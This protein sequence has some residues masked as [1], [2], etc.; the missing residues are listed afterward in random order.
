MS[1]A[2]PLPPHPSLEHYR[3]QAK[4]LLK[5]CRSG[6]AV[7]I[8]HWQI[9][10][11]LR[12]R[13]E[14]RLRDANIE[15][16]T[17]AQLFI[18]RAHGF[19]SWP[20]F[21]GHVE[22][23]G[24]RNSPDALFEAAVD[25]VVGGD[26]AAL[27]RLLSDHPELVHARSTREHHST[28]LHYA[29]AN[30]VEDFRQR[31]PP[32]IVD[33][34]TLLLDEGAGVNAESDA[35]GGRSTTLMLV[36]T[37]VHPERAGVQIAL[38][39]LLLGRGAFI[40]HRPATAVNACLA[41]GRVEAAEFLAARGAR[42]DLPGAAG[43]GR[44]DVVESFFRDAVPPADDMQRAFRYACQFDRAA[45]VEFLLD[46][47]A[48]ICA[49]DANGMTPLHWA[50]HA[51]AVDIVELLLARNAPL[52][53]TNAYGGT[54]LGQAVWS[55]IHE[56]RARH[57]VTIELLVA[58][59]AR[60]SDDWFTGRAWIDE[61]LQRDAHPPRGSADERVRELKQRAEQAR[62]EG[63]FDEA[64]RDYTDAVEI[65]RGLSDRLLLAHT[66]RH[67][68]DVEVQLG[69][70]DAAEPL[71]VEA[72]AIYRS[73]QTTPLELANAIRSLAL[74]KHSAGA[75][76]DATRLWEEAHALYVR[77]NV[78]PAVAETASRLAQLARS[79]RPPTR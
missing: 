65:C 14:R 38:M 37:S 18:A 75:V 36:A 10:S 73:E 21:A 32:N 71:F 64:K 28:L 57:R 3:K 15:Q 5:A 62:R 76:A 77:A 66:V 13:I 79:G 59:G 27:R 44:L 1:D 22:S 34:A 70:P 60:V 26:I 58:A 30:G 7:P 39:E 78:P 20:K 54:V 4:K 69:R 29:S 19:E 43:A 48:D 35:Y 11:E 24:R 68:G 49:A 56:S 61:A 12:E 53:A 47:G 50:A 63:R 23:L 25:A 41:N 6:D 67:L 2:I 8:S 55:A 33:V 17:D 51:A 16:L 9:E 46:R 74:L 52:E 31:T 45:I 72:L 40:E 42:L